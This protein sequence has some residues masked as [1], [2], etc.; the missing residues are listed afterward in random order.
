MN[1]VPWVMQVGQNL[2]S[3]AGDIKDMVRLYSVEQPVMR[4]VEATVGVFKAYRLATLLLE[5]CIDA[6]HFHLAVRCMLYV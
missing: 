6:H 2:Q 5:A 1:V 4:N 3:K